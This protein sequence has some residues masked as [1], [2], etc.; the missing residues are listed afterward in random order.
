[1]NTPTLKQLSIIHNVVSAYH[2]SKKDESHMTISIIKKDVGDGG[3]ESFV[4]TEPSPEECGHA[5]F[6]VEFL[7]VGDR[8]S[9]MW[10][11]RLACYN[12]NFEGAIDGIF[13]V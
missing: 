3:V 9:N 2:A 10:A 6:K 4:I 12:A 5:T 1:M 13:T 7:R 8:T 11:Y